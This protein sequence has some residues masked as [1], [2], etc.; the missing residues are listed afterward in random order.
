MLD[1][2]N[3]VVKFVSVIRLILDTCVYFKEMYAGASQRV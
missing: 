3:V 1:L 2:I